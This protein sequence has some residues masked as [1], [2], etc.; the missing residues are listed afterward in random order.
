MRE[1]ANVIT[2]LDSSFDSNSIWDLF[3]LGKYKVDSV[4]SRPI[5]VKFLRATDVQNILS[6][7]RSLSHPFSIQL[8]M[9]PTERLQHSAL[10]KERWSIIQSG[11]ERKNIKIRNTSIYVNNQLYG[12]LDSNN[13]FQQASPP[14][15]SSTLSEENTSVKN[16][17][18]HIFNPSDI[19]PAST[20][21]SSIPLEV[22]SLQSILNPSDSQQSK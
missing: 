4:R 18:L 10:L 16:V 12:K 5:L 11:I 21:N 7:K 17:T 15:I 1:V 9:S 2:K 13:K 6:R 8:D 20:A 22:N 19:T 3:R 14:P